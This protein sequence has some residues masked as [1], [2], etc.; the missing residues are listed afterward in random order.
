MAGTLG[1]Y[2]PLRYRGYVYDEETGLY[3]PQSRYYDPEMG[4]FI[5]AD[6]YISTGQGL[7]GNTMFAYCFNNPVVFVDNT[8]ENPA[9][10]I[11]E[12]V[13]VSLETLLPIVAVVAVIVVVGPV[14]E[15]V[16]SRGYESF[17]TAVSTFVYDWT[18]PRTPYCCPE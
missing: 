2:N 14:V 9:A 5:N 7:L 13:A 3:Y 10:A 8:G 18:V 16:I 4:R 1:F 15:D 12:G 6:D 11:F 17:T